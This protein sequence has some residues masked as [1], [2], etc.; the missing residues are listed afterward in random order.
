MKTNLDL[1]TKLHYELNLD[2]FW[3]VSIRSYEVQ[4]MGWHTPELEKLL[5]DKGYQLKW[6]ELY[7]NYRFDEN[8]V[9]IILSQKPK[10]DN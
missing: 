8:G 2:N 1:A 7:G 10:N 4:L 3:T 5:F 9:N 6:D